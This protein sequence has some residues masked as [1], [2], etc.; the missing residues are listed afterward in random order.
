MP[1]ADIYSGRGIVRGANPHF[2]SKHKFRGPHGETFHA[3]QERPWDK[4]KKNRKN[5]EMARNSR[6]RNRK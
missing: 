6:R 4:K 2:H 1:G 3:T 5:N